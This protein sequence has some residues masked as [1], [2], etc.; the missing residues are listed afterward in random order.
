MAV[1]IFL[2]IKYYLFIIQTNK[3]DIFMKLCHI[4]KI[5]FKKYFEISLRY[6]YFL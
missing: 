6:F 3:K 1:L 2:F 4:L 5:V